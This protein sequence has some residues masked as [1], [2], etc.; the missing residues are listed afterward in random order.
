[1]SKKLIKLNV[2]AILI[3]ALIMSVLAVIRL[4]LEKDMVRYSTI[5]KSEVQLNEGEYLITMPL[6]TLLDTMEQSNNEDTLRTK[7]IFDEVVFNLAIYQKD[8]ITKTVEILPVLDDKEKAFDQ[9]I[10]GSFT[11]EQKSNYVID[12]SSEYDDVTKFYYLIGNSNPVLYDVARVIYS[13][14]FIFTVIFLSFANSIVVVK[15]WQDRDL[16]RNLNKG[17]D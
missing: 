3:I 17:S 4:T 2:V 7:L 8:D 9:Y 12:A 1:M 5:G 13:N 15:K 10:I 14:G 6:T 16:K 11:I